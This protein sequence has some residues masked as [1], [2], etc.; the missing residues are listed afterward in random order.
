MWLEEP[1]NNYL[2]V[3]SAN[4]NLFGKRFG[5]YKSI[6]HTHTAHAHGHQHGSC[7]NENVVHAASSQKFI[8]KEV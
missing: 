1:P 6:A 7:R 4:F 3:L 5:Q 2:K 8:T